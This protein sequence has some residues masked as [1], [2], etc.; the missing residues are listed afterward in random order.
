MFSPSSLS[1]SDDTD[2][3][4]VLANSERVNQPALENGLAWLVFANAIRYTSDGMKTMRL[5]HL[6]AIAAMLPLVACG[7]SEGNFRRGHN[8]QEDILEGNHWRN[9]MPPPRSIL[10]VAGGRS[11]WMRDRSISARRAPLPR[12]EPLVDGA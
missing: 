9:T 11:Q 2:G 12:F 3:C 10:S 6:I 1:R 4:R 5:T 8:G 7:D